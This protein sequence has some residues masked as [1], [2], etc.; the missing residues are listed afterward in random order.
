[1]A[2]KGLGGI[3]LGGRGQLGG[4]GRRAFRND[5]KVFN[6]YGH[7][8]SCSSEHVNGHKKMT[9]AKIGH[10]RAILGLMEAACVGIAKAAR[11]TGEVPITCGEITPKLKV[12][13]F[14]N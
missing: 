9:M 6:G 13:F 7:D 4:R 11:S 10:D 3:E 14:R 12:A 2:G 1:M 8:Q 5:T